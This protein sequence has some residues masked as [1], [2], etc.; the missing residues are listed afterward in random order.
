MKCAICGAELEE[1]AKFCGNCG[2]P[3]ESTDSIQTEETVTN[4]EVSSEPAVEEPKTE[5]VVEEPKAEEEVSLE[6]F[7]S[8]VSNEPQEERQ[9]IVQEPIPVDTKEFKDEQEKGKKSSK[10][11]KYILIV[12]AIL[13]VLGAAAFVYLKFFFNK[14]PYQKSVDTVEKSVQN[15]ADEVVKNKG[16]KITAKLELAIKDSMSF[17]FTGF[18]EFQKVDDEF[19]LH[20]RL[21]KGLLD[22][23]DLYVEFN[24]VGV[25]AYI[26]MSLMEQFAD[27]DEIDSMKMIVGKN[28]K[29]LK[30]G[31]TFEELG[32]DGIDE[33]FATAEINTDADLD[34][35][36]ILTSDNFKYIGKKDG[37]KKYTL[38]VDKNFLK[39]YSKELEEAGMPLDDLDSI[40]D[41]KFDMNFYVKDD[42]LVRIELDMKDALKSSQVEAEKAMITIDFNEVEGNVKVPEDVIKSS[43]DLNAFSQQTTTKKTTTTIP[44]TTKLF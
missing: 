27:E 13:A 18:V 15:L 11:V 34:L 4:N 24:K 25:V 1:N 31:M 30:Y 12:I 14:E 10:A 2:N 32:F 5:E 3:V 17:S 8:E 38:T 23:T 9:E 22:Q 42:I 33:I 19:T 16:G 20:A 6:P 39:D 36:K 43:F 37:V 44:Q 41:M 26:P 7:S 28:T 35:S 40:G 21:E 29:F